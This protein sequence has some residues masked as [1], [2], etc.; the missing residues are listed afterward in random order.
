MK[1]NSRLNP[2]TPTRQGPMSTQ[3]PSDPFQNSIDA[4]IAMEA[5]AH[6]LAPT[7]EER[8]RQLASVCRTAA[9]ILKA[10]LSAGI[11]D[12][13]PDPWSPSTWEFLAKHTLRFR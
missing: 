9:A 11:P 4:I 7:F 5:D 13:E 1:E 6:V 12:P 8:A 3:T 10:R 2:I